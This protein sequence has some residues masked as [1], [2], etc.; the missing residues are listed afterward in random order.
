MSSEFENWCVVATKT[1]QED[2]AAFNLRKQSYTVYAPR[3]IRR[4][5]HARKISMVP[6]PLY[7]R[8]LFVQLDPKIRRWRPINS[9]F[10]VSHILCV[11]EVP[12]PVDSRVIRELKSRED[13]SGFVRLEPQRTLKPGDNVRVLDG[14][15][16]SK[17]GLFEGMTDG[18]R[19]AILL[20]LLGREVRI[21]L[22]PESIEAAR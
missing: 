10:G 1:H 18:D 13:E 6:R 11:G 19:V 12:T 2:K 5:K 4:V 7:P 22:D 21:K 3:F 16:A 9:T 8:Y 17:L 20:N 15:F 14:A